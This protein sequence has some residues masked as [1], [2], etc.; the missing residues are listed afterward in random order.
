MHTTKLSAVWKQF[1]LPLKGLRELSYKFD[2][3][4]NPGKNNYQNLQV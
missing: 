1:R 2:N 3:D 4:V